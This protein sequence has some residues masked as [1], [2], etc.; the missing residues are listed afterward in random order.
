MV[1]YI[2]CI[3]TGRSGSHYLATILNNCNNIKSYHEPA[4]IMNGEVMIEYLKGNKKPIRPLLDKKIE[5]IKKT[6]NKDDVYIET[7]HTFI[8]GFGWEIVNKLPKSQL[9]V[10]WLKRDLKDIVESFYR[11]DN[12]PL[13]HNG[14]I[15]MFNPLMKHLE[16]KISLKFKLRYKIL[17]FLNRFLKSKY[18]KSFFKFKKPFFFVA[19]EKKYLKWY[20]QETDLQ[21]ER[22][23]EKFPD[24]KFFELNTRQLNKPEVYKAM[25]DF[26]EID[27][28]PKDSFYSN[29]GKLTNQKNS[30]KK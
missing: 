9:A 6:I 24:I 10:I 25:F 11:I 12:T 26:F 18:N 28:S 29:I 2:F 14:L 30:S 3:N 5:F 22:F 20:V 15:W 19:Q 4:P 21:A 1:K 17:F 16:T 13:N 7:N 8:K 27:F 23:K